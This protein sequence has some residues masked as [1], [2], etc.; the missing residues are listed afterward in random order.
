MVKRFRIVVALAMLKGRCRDS[1]RE[2]DKLLTTYH[3]IED[4]LSCSFRLRTRESYL[5]SGR[6]RETGEMH[7]AY[8]RDW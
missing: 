8:I 1:T 3:I 5:T 2:I 4:A 7:I 6:S